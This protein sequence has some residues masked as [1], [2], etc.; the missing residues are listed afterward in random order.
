MNEKFSQKFI[1]PTYD[2]DDVLILPRSSEL[3]S[4]SEVNL[5][6]SYIT[7]HS[8]KKISGVP[9]IVANMASVATINM[10]K[11]LYN[12]KMFVALH[13]FIPGEELVE[14]LW[15]KES[16][17]SFVT[18]GGSDDELTRIQNL[19]SYKDYDIP[20]ICIDVA[21]GYCYSFLDQIK[22]VRDAFPKSVILAGNV[23]TA[24]G[25]ENII[26]AGA[27][28]AKCGI[29]QGGGCDTKSMTGVGLR[30]F[31][32]AMECGQAANELNALCCSDGGVKCVGDI[33]KG[34]GSGSHFI[35]C[36]NLFSGYEE[37]DH[38][39][40]EQLYD[41]GITNVWKNINE[42]VDGLYALGEKRFK[43]FGMS[44]KFANDQFCGGLKEYRASEGKEFY[45]DYRGNVDELCKEIKGGL[46]SCC[47]Y[48]N[49]KNLENLHKNCQF[50]Y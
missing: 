47:T 8:K 3:K 25:V 26:K 5:E 28:I 7:K 35:M 31:T 34:L 46:A 24:S 40:L 1:G 4:R 29:S 43:F 33:C 30:Q 14:F 36:G 39:Y 27:D 20:Y 19:S 15:Q 12:H 37:N 16:V 10:A 49:T 44:S 6:V 45:V 13:K 48:T 17:Y 18:I 50:S 11:E 32:T 38:K 41:N 22:K 42:N 21:N 2:F 23:C 9:V